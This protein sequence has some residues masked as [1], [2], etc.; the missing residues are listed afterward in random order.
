MLNRAKLPK[1]MR[2]KLQAE[3]ENIARKLDVIV[4]HTKGKE[5]PYKQVYL[6]LPKYVNNL[7]IFG[8]VG[9]ITIRSGKIK[10][11]LDDCGVPGLFTGYPDNYSLDSF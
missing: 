7:C 2:D 5:C 6:K 9:I 3:A 1:N 10:A 4:S 11:K 8:E